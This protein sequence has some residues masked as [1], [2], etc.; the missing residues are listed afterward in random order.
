MRWQCNGVA[1]HFTRTARTAWRL[2][3]YFLTSCWCYE[4]LLSMTSLSYQ[5]ARPESWKA[6]GASEVCFLPEGDIH[7]MFGV[8]G[9]SLV[10]CNTHGSFV[11]RFQTPVTG[12]VVCASLLHARTICI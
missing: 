10:G 8:G 11:F 7:D 5:M 1:K 12:M 2:G 6:A 9:N 4:P 3:S